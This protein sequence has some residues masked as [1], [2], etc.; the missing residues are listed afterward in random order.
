MN[1]KDAVLLFSTPPEQIDLNTSSREFLGEENT[2]DVLLKNEQWL[3][4]T[5]IDLKPGRQSLAEIQSA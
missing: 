5:A 2:L 3:K 1:Q 4:L